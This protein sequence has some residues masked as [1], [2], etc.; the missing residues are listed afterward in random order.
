MFGK[1]DMQGTEYDPNIQYAE[2]RPWPH[3]QP[4]GWDP[5]QADLPPQD[6]TQAANQAGDPTPQPKEK[7]PGRRLS[8]ADYIK[9]VRRLREQQIAMGMDPNQA[10]VPTFGNVVG[11]SGDIS[12][13]MGPTAPGGGPPEGE[14]RSYVTPEYIQGRD[15]M[16]RGPAHPVTQGQKR[17]AGRGTSPSKNPFDPR[18][19]NT[20]AIEQL[21]GAV[22]KYEQ[23]KGGGATPGEIDAI[24]HSLR[25]EAIKV[26]GEEQKQFKQ[27]FDKDTDRQTMW[28]AW[29]TGDIQ[30]ALEARRQAKSAENRQ[31]TYNEYYE[32]FEDFQ[33]KN[34]GEQ[35]ENPD[36]GEAY[37]D[38]DEYAKAK[39]KEIF[40]A[41]DDMIKVLQDQ[42]Q[43]G[44]GKPKQKGDA[45]ATPEGEDIQG[46]LAKKKPKQAPDGNWYVE[47]NG[48]YYKAPAPK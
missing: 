33:M 14:L 28:K 46:I 43:Y 26:L 31:K 9:E 22:E 45:S 15:G 25:K 11:G 32:K 29:E 13:G 17:A 37:A 10:A 8:M 18:S 23:Q 42:A 34:P 39:V 7:Q 21:P 40:T 20:I 5:N 12:H 16:Q 35:I 19:A 44:G 4:E 1:D 47:H 6:L 36:T 24:A 30:G 2:E 48:Q 27:F 3:N 41:M 38:A